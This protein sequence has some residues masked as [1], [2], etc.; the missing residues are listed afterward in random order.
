[1]RL[2][3]ALAPQVALAKLLRE[4]VFLFRTADLPNGISTK[5]LIIENGS[6]YK[7]KQIDPVFDIAY[8]IVGILIVF[9]AFGITLLVAQT[10]GLDTITQIF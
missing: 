3:T 2:Q 6:T 10:L 9:L 5:D 4:P 1:V 8:F 7:I